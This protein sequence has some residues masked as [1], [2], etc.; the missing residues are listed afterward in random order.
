VDQRVQVTYV[1]DGDTFTLSSGRRVRL[2]EINAPEI[3]H[4]HPDR[5]EPG[6]LEARTW[7]R[8]QLGPLPA[9]VGLQFDVRRED[10]Y[11]RLLAHVQLASGRN[12]SATLLREG[13][14]EFRVIPPNTLYW[15]CYRQQQALARA[16]RKGQWKT[17]FFASKQAVQVADDAHG[18]VRLQGRISR[19]VETRRTHWLV[20]DERVW[21][22]VRRSDESL[23][24]EGFH[25]L[26]LHRQVEVTGWLYR[27]H[28]HLRIRLRHPAQIEILTS[29][30][31]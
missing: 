30:V 19:V 27:S 1:N 28:E 17:G 15:R 14:A 31:Q 11:G 29:A 2:L 4:R 3:D 13:L 9:T 23:F 16:E 5:S 24:P 10:K 7:L 20:L 25:T 22:G 12:L 18:W 6:G 26:W 21:L 8:R